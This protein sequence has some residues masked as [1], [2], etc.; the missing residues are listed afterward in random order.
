MSTVVHVTRMLGVIT[1]TTIDQWQR[2]NGVRVD[3]AEC[4]AQWARAIAGDRRFRAGI[5][6]ARLSARLLSAAAFLH[7]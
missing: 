3:P 4:I 2:R 5:I 7:T 6:A 1:F